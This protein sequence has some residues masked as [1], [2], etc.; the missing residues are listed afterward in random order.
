MLRLRVVGPIEKAIGELSSATLATVDASSEIADSSGDLAEGASRQAAALEQ[1]TASL[2]EI[3]SATRRNLA[4]TSESV[5]LASLAR[6]VVDQAVGRM[7]SL[8]AA[9]GSISEAG[10]EISKI[11]KTI[12]EI[13][14][15]TN[16]LALNAAVEAAR[17]GEAGAGFSVVAD[18]VR[19]LA[20]RASAASQD[21]A[22]RI[23]RSVAASAEGNKI[24]TAVEAELD[25]VTQQVHSIEGLLLVLQKNSTQ[26]ATG[27]E[28]VS[29]AISEIDKVIQNS[30]SSSEELASASTEMQGQISS[31]ERAIGA[32]LFVV[33]GDAVAAIDSRSL[34]PSGTSPAHKRELKI[35]PDESFLLSERNQRW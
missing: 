18:E 23:Q 33:S 4:S 25:S 2:E 3:S 31:L 32:L 28:Q 10:G 11:I 15:Q 13:A 19:Q 12:E 14:F 22:H 20:M 1:A 9:M 21:S 7:K 8:R 29:S 24:S 34:N 26:Q 5:E 35:E 30:A 17:A 27:I 6:G 16:I